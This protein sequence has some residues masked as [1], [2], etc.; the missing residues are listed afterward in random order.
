MVHPSRRKPTER[1]WYW[2]I[3]FIKNHRPWFWQAQAKRMVFLDGI[4]HYHQMLRLRS[5]AMRIVHNEFCDSPLKMKRIPP[6][7][8]K[9]WVFR[10]Q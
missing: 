2:A 10:L 4:W 8:R 9:W 3:A 5:R 7:P 6:D 1:E